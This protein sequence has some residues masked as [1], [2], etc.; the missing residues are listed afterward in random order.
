MYPDRSDGH[1]STAAY[2]SA[3]LMDDEQ[4][5]RAEWVALGY[6]P[7]TAWAGSIPP[8]DGQVRF[9][10]ITGNRARAHVRRFSSSRRPRVARSS[11]SSNRVATTGSRSPLAASSGTSDPSS[12]AARFLW[13]T[14]GAR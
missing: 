4:A 5:A 8:P 2:G 3:L 6:D 13:L 14:G 1:P 11:A 9:L 7:S 12:R 10:T